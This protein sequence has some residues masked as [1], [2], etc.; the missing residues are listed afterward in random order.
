MNISTVTVFVAVF[1]M[2]FAMG[3]QAY[4]YLDPGT[5]SVLLQVLLGG[6]AGALALIKLYWKRI[7]SVIS[8][9][10]SGEA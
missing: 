2:T 5:G 6:V 10:S 7:K 9:R 4:A 3:D 8:R 1:L